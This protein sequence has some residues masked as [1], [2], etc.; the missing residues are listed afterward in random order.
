MIAPSD[1]LDFYFKNNFRLVFWPHIGDAKGPRE[2]GWTEKVYTRDDYR[3]TMRVGLMC[4]HEI[5]PGKFLH[6]V[7][8]DW[9]P[10]SRIAQALIP[11]TEFVFGRANKKI[12][13]C[14]Y[15]L[16]EAV[17]SFKYE[18]PTD[19][20]CLIELRGCKLDG[21][22]GNQTMCPPS[23]WS[24]DS[25]REPLEFVKFRIPSHFEDIPKFKQKVCLSAIAMLLAKHFGKQG[26]GHEIRLAWA[27]FLLR[28]GISIE[29]CIAVGNAIM[30]Y[31]GN[32]D[33]T[34]IKLAVESTNKRLLDKDKKVKGGPALAKMIGEHGRAIVKRINEWL[35]R[36]SDFIRNQDGLII[37]DHQENVV[38]A[39]SLLNVELKYNEFAD[40]LLVNNQPL[41]DRQL[42]EVWFRI[43]E[44]C[45]F[46]PPID[47]FEKVI[48]RIGWNNAFHPVRDYFNTLQWDGKPRIDT[49]LIDSANAFDNPYIRAISAIFL[50]AAVRRIKQPGCK[51]DELIVLESEQGLQKSSALR[52]LCPHA[53]WFSDDFQL[54]ATSQRMIEATTGKWIIEVSELSGMRQSMVELLKSNLSRQ[55]DGPA[56]M[57]YAHLPIERPRQFIL[58]GTTN[59]KN[60]LAD[61]TG[62][63]RFWPIDVFRFNVEWIINNRDQLWA[64]AVHREA[65][66][67][68]N[69][70]HESLWKYAGEEQERRREVDPWE[71]LI[72]TALLSNFEI[73]YEDGY[74]RVVTS[75]L[76][77]SLGIEPSRRERKYQTRLSEI[78]QRLGFERTRVRPAGEQVQVGYISTGQ[79]WARRAALE[80][81]GAHDVVASAQVPPDQNDM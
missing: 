67:E 26:F 41:E 66:G 39:L 5:S 78:M 25:A 14:W 60:Y 13:H 51:H 63:R 1:V 68:S 11:P 30:L 15:T 44:E 79:D 40:K 56:R 2:K 9:E 80:D 43:D 46:R 81:A 37:K 12:S 48:K 72:R 74:T 50:I 31:T 58:I 55:V 77:D 62:S 7:D 22:L 17:A 4:G 3:E 59:S 23:V 35:G 34:D 16:P 61:S 71:S 19:K 33:K 8:I 28:A 20:T 49:W 47:F 57:A 21:T 32:S 54:N 53:D 38:R 29:E 73:H 18:D 52:A 64:E 42:N 65:L 45:K 76:W 24:R 27:G 75:F 36:D 6:D 70:L 10:G 69:R